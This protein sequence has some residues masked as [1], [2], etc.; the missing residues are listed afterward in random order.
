MTRQHVIVALVVLFTGA[1]CDRSD[2]VEAQLKQ[3]AISSPDDGDITLCH[4]PP[5]NPQKPQT[6]V[7][8]LPSVGNHLSHGDAFGPCPD[9]PC[10]ENGLACSATRYCCSG[11]CDSTRTCADVVVECT[12]TGAACLSDG[13]CCTGVCDVTSATCAE[14]ACLAQGEPCAHDHECCSAAC[15][16]TCV[17]A[18]NGCLATG[19]PCQPDTPCC[20]GLCDVSRAEGAVCADATCGGI[21]RACSADSEC[22]SGFCDQSMPDDPVCSG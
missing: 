14:R 17:D 19:E 9:G 2:R 11:N 7:V 20:G 16:G 15:D 8:A 1:S 6:L 21:G 4:L 22:C 18:P 5:D 13:Q 10:L 3:V 12:A